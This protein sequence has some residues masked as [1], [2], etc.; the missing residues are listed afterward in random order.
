[1]NT[2]R[3]IHTILS[4]GLFSLLLVV[5]SLDLRGQDPL[6]F[7]TLELLIKQIK[8]QN[9]SF[10]WLLNAQGYCWKLNGDSTYYLNNDYIL[11]NP[12]PIVLD[13]DFTQI[14]GYNTSPFEEDSVTLIAGIYRLRILEDGDAE[15]IRIYYVP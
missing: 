13:G 9:R 8:T 14:N 2:R 5:P 12:R 11:L 15:K 7:P 4:S 3:T 10:T 6:W 1:M